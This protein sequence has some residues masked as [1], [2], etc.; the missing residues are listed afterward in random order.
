ML[1]NVM[2]RPSKLTTFAI[3]PAANRIF[4]FAHHLEI[5]K[6]NL[7]TRSSVVH[8]ISETSEFESLVN[9]DQ[10]YGAEACDWGWRRGQTCLL[11]GFVVG[12]I[13][14]ACSWEEAGVEGEVE[15]VLTKVVDLCC[16]SE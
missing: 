6:S 8:A 7:L 12:W 13:V 15:V 14:K 3:A 11:V 10:R 2:S 4:A 1:V 5:T 16:V 9:L